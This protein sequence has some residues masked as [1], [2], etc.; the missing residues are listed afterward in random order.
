MLLRLSGMDLIRNEFKAAI[1]RGEPQIGLWATL[2]DP[3]VMELLAGSGFDWLLLDA[4][5]APNDVGTILPQL[6]AIAPYPV[7]AVVRPPWND[8]VLIK[9]YLD[10]GTQTLMLP[11]VQNEAEARAA[12]AA[13]RYPTRGVRGVAGGTRATPF[14][15]MPE[16]AQRAHEEIC[17]LVQVE[18]REALANIQAI[19]AVDGIDGVFIGPADLSASMGHLGNAAHPE[20]AAAI[21][22]AIASVRQCGKAPGILMADEVRARRYI[23]NGALFV[24]VGIDVSILAR[25]TEKL[26]A[27]F[28]KEA[29]PPSRDGGTG[30]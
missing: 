3:Y 22:D 7:S 14:G 28:R 8:M 25:E 1:K 30:Y 10:I 23:D 21:D 29:A 24:A 27:R 2:A 12:V 5:H 9:R 20:V 26:A 13:V 4:E 18:T 15:R 16:Y 11:Y 19:A 17:V 6:Q